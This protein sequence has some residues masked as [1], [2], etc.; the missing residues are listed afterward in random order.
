MMDKREKLIQ[1]R[2]EA[3][4]GGGKERIAAQ[5][6][7]GKLTARERIHLFLDEGSFNEIGAFVTHRSTDFGMEN[8][9]VLGDGVVTGYGTVNGRLT[10]VFSQDF[11]VFGGSL[12]E[13]FAEKICKV[14]D[15]A[16]KSGAPV[17]GLIDSGGAR[18][19]V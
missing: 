17:I 15:L 10:Y 13:T 18:K 9:I 8:Q 4:L 16:M 14:M 5:H 2:E 3:L 19:K 7:K 12:S 1:M 11:T 6:K